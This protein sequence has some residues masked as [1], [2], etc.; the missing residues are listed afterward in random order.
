MVSFGVM[1]MSPRICSLISDTIDQYS[2]T[3]AKMKITLFDLELMSEH[4]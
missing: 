2:I 4:Y 3:I 1:K